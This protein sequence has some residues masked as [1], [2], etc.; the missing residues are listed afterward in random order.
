MLLAD[1]P[2]VAGILRLLAPTLEIAKDRTSP[3]R[4]Q[5]V[6]RSVG[7]FRRMMDLTDVHDRGHAGVDLREAPEHLV[8]VDVLRPIDHRELLENRLVIIVR[9]LGPTAVA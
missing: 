6:D 8:H 1:A 3:D 9:A 4:A 2:G 7:M 5:P